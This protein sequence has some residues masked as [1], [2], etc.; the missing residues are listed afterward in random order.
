MQELFEGFVKKLHY[1][2]FLDRAQ[3]EMGCPE[4]YWES[5]LLLYYSS[6]S[7]QLVLLETVETV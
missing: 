2:I 6:V 1:I 3:N 5:D 7:M 4:A